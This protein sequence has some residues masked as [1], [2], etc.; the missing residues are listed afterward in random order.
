MYDVKPFTT[1]HASACGP[2]CL[3]M[4]LV[5][6]GKE[7]PFDTLVA[8]CGITVTGTTISNLLRVGKAHGLDM[9]AYKMDAQDV[10]NLDRPAIIHWRY[11]HFVVFCGRDENGE[12]VICN[13]ASGRFS[14]PI[15]DFKRFYTGYALTNGQ[16]DDAFPEDYF[17]EK[18]E[19]PDNYF[20]G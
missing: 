7:I 20:D 3:K 4:I 11:T 5:Y 9:R 19:E 13:S 18:S 17:G 10:L 15:D 1:A 14:L 12:P 2:A 16:N 6:Y 8:E